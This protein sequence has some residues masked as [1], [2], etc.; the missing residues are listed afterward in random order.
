MYLTTNRDDMV[1][2]TCPP[3]PLVRDLVEV[4]L[5]PSFPFAFLVVRVTT[6]VMKP[7]LIFLITVTYMPIY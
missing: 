3:Q 1:Q 4:K 6:S 7:K 5:A 2:L